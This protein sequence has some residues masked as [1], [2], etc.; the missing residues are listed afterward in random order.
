MRLQ[1]VTG[2]PRVVKSSAG[3]RSSNPKANIPPWYRQLHYNLTHREDEVTNSPLTPPT[4]RV[5]TSK[6]SIRL[7]LES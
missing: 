3:R 1:G 4:G 2:M 7:Y 6:G 5:I